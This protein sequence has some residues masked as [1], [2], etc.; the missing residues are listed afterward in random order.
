MKVPASVPH[1]SARL[2]NLLTWFGAS[3]LIT[4]G[5]IYAVKQR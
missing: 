3:V 2:E 5:L 4:A 1:L